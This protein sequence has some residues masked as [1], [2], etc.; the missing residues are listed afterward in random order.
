MFF[1]LLGILFDLLGEAWPLVLALLGYLLFGKAARQGNKKAAKWGKWI[2]EVTD[3]PILDEEKKR[4]QA[5]RTSRPVAGPDV[6]YGWPE[7]KQRE[8]QGKE[9]N[10]REAGAAGKAAVT[11]Q[12]AAVSASPPRADRAERPAAA[13]PAAGAVVTWKPLSPAAASVSRSQPQL[14]AGKREGRAGTVFDPREGFKWA[15]IFS[16]PRAKAAYRPPSRTDRLI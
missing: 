10:L 5:K 16:P 4:K 7:H 11:T 15:I 3:I 14:A 6:R 12:P 2:E 13:A 1:D 8:N 9:A